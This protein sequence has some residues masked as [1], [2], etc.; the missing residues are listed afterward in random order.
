MPNENGYKGGE[1]HS[2][3]ELR[4]ENMDVVVTVY[5]LFEGLV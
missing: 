4:G 1:S 2:L 5:S 3:D